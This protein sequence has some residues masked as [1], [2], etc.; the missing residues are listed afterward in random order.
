[1]LKAVE[2]I[3]MP[4]GQRAG[5]DVF[6]GRESIDVDVF[7]QAPESEPIPFGE[8]STGESMSDRSDNGNSNHLAAIGAVLATHN[9]SAGGLRDSEGSGGGRIN[10]HTAPIDVIEA[11]M[12]EA[13][14]GGLETIIAARENG[15]H[16]QLG[17]LPQLVEPNESAPQLVTQT[18]TWAFRID[19]R[20]GSV[21]KSWWSIYRPHED[22]WRCV[23]RLV[24]NE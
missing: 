18:D 5:L 8:G 4:E 22:S 17:T 9:K 20:V 6:A 23:Q 2:P 24:I 21:Q 13:G 3:E 14:R 7:P 16:V 1:V 11:A 19:V 10:I 15:E 12:R